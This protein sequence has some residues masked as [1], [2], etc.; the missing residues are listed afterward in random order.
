MS[1]IKNHHMNELNR[2]L[3]G[4]ASCKYQSPTSSSFIFSYLRAGPVLTPEASNEQ[5]WYRSIR[6][7]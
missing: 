5:T 4:D 7:C 3:L 1:Q 6:R 2:G